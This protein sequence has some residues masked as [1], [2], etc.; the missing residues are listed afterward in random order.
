MKK[1]LLLNVLLLLL[2]GYASA[3]CGA[4]EVKVSINIQTDTWGE[5][6]SWTLTDLKGN[7]VL[8][9]GQGGVYDDNTNYKDS[10]CV[11]SN[12]CLFFEIYDVYGDGINAPNGCKLY[13][14][15]VLVYSGAD[16]IGSYAKTIVNCSDSCSLVINGLNDLQSH[17]NGNITLSGDDLTVIKNVMTLFPAC[18]AANES[19]ILLSNSVVENYEFKV[20]ALF[21]TPKTI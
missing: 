21:T 16:N 2:T 3:Q 10:V 1:N 4:N 9:G 15:N 7:V 5:E 19:S 17:I 6:T 14:D 13:L 11:L 8:N 12:E 18:L 20:G